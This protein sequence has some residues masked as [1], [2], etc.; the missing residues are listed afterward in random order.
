MKQLLSL[1]FVIFTITAYSQARVSVDTT[2]IRIG[3]QITYTI[4]ADK[5]KN[6]VF[7][8]LKLKPSGGLE[9]VKSLP[10]DTL[11]DRLSKKYLITS[12]D[13]GA[14]VIPAQQLKINGVTQRLD[15]LYI[16]VR[17][18]AVDTTKQALHPIKTIY[19]APPKT[20]RDYLP[21]IWWLLVLG[22]I[23]ALVWLFLK[24]RTK[25]IESDPE[26]Q[27]TPYQWARIQLDDLDHSKLLING[28]IKTYYS[29]LTT[30]VRHYLETDFKIPALEYTTDELILN[31]KVA[32]QQ[33]KYYF[34][35]KRL[36]QLDL[37]LRSA[38]LVKFAKAKPIDI[39]IRE[40]RKFAEQFINELHDTIEQKRAKDAELAQNDPNNPMVLQKQR[41]YR[42]RWFA[43]IGAVVGV[44]VIIALW[45]YFGTQ[46]IKDRVLG[47]AN[48]RL[49]DKEWFTSHYGY[50]SVAVY[51]PFV[52]KPTA[53]DLPKHISEQAVGLA[54]FTYGKPYGRFFMDLNTLEMQPQAPVDAQNF[55]TNAVEIL[56]STKGLKDLDY[57]ITDASISGFSGQKLAGTYRFKGKTYQFEHYLIPVKNSLVNVSTAYRSDD[58]YGKKLN[59]KLIQALKIERTDL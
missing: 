48:K 47:N 19:K 34:D 45:S 3:E 8:K 22:V 55:M 56:K 43:G 57:K 39:N 50:P 27:H 38:D 49:F 18:I 41:N 17:T 36:D 30:I 24:Y 4:D 44:V 32:D 28:K 21:V 11:K 10:V 23:G 20:W 5:T 42:N 12:F 59:D 13:S 51:A 29:E 15:S 37:F 31:L 9:L 53:S 7:P 2:T 16:N 40:D 25:T 33:H 35:D 26:K 46:T 1:F 52:L 54:H 6:V 14:F 58:N